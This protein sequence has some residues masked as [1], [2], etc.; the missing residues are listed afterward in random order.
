VAAYRRYLKACIKEDALVRAF[1]L[2]GPAARTGARS[3]A[4]D[5]RVSIAFAVVDAA[6]I[7]TM[8]FIAGHGF[9][10]TGL[11]PFDLRKPLGRKYVRP[12]H[13]DVDRK[14][15]ALKPHLLHTGSRALTDLAFL[16]L[17]AS[18]LAPEEVAEL[19]WKNLALERLT[20]PGE[21]GRLDPDAGAEDEERA[22][23]DLLDPEGH[24]FG[25][26]LAGDERVGIDPIKRGRPGP[27]EA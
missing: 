6:K 2:L 10:A 13:D 4:S 25:K 5:S 27:R 21:V 12:C 26:L 8:T 24:T 23:I 19:E 7:A 16:Q 3:N 1:S 22:E 17:L 15:E 11:F 9:S 18:R 20:G 14:R